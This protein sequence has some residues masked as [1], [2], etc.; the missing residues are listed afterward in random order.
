MAHLLE[1]TYQT[2][3]TVGIHVART[4]TYKLPPSQATG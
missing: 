3:H 1:H 4:H 2:L